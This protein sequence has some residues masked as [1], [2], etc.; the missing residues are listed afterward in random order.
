MICKS[1]IFIRPVMKKIFTTTICLLL[2]T[3]AHAQ[4]INE[5]EAQQFLEKVWG[6]LKTSDSVSFVNLWLPEDSVWQRIHTP[7]GGTDYMKSFHWLQD[8]LFPA[9]ISDA[10][11]EPIEIGNEDGKGNEIT[12]MFNTRLH[13]RM[14]FSFHVIKINDNWSARS[15]PHFIAGMDDTK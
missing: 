4:K 10:K 1:F 7:I 11:M 3:V 13:G 2:L 15:Q 12:A 6:Y 5:K 9:I 14:G 8:F